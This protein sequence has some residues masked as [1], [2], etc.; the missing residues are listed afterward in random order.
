MRKIVFL[1]ITLSL[2]LS[3]LTSCTQQR[4]AYGMLNEFITAYGA[5]GVIYSPCISEGEVGYVQD[6][7]EEKIFVFSG[8]FPENYAIFL[9]SRTDKP[10]E[11]GIFVCEDAAMLAM[12]EEACLERIKLLGQ[13]GDHTFVKRRGD[14]VYYSVMQDKE[15][16]EALLR[17]IIR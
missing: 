5:E 15:R 12:M 14:V 9:N 8:R 10:S 2:L 16:A 13:G 3:V 17:E 1:I 4:D 7:L 11:C 6:G